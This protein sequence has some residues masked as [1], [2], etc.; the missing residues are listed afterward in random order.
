M[1]ILSPPCRHRTRFRDAT[2]H[3]MVITATIRPSAPILALSRSRLPQR[4]Q[5]RIL[6]GAP[7]NYLKINVFIK[8]ISATLP[9]RIYLGSTG[10]ALQTNFICATGASRRRHLPKKLLASNSWGICPA[11]PSSLRTLDARADPAPVIHYAPAENLERVDVA[12]IDRAE[13]ANR[14]EGIGAASGEEKCFK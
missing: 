13:H 4:P 7:L 11:L 14:L 8:S 2:L 12:L 5:V 3:A 1:R 6:S 10:A 9:P